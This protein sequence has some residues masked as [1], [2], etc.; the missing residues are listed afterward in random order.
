VSRS[1]LPYVIT[2]QLTLSAVLFIPILWGEEFGWRGYMQKRW[3]KGQPLK[4]ALEGQPLKAALAT[5]LVWGVWHYPVNL[6]GYN[7]P[8]HPYAGL[9]VFPIATVFLSII[10]GW[11]YR[12]TGSIWA[13]SLGHASLNSIGGS[14]SVLLFAGTE[15]SLV[16]RSSEAAQ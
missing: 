2:L 1:I 15:G 9:V 12:R 14:L 13:P 11:L 7:F 6:Q 8:N 10:L 16:R 5:G 3:F 4:A